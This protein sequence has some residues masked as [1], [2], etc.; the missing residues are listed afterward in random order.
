MFFGVRWPGIA[1]TIQR[2]S[3]TS[4]TFVGRNEQTQTLPELR[5]LCCGYS[6]EHGINGENCVCAV[7][8]RLCDLVPACEKC[9]LVKLATYESCLQ[10]V[11]PLVS[12]FGRHA[13]GT[14]NLR[15]GALSC[16]SRLD[17]YR[18]YSILSNQKIECDRG[19]FGHTRGEVA[20]VASANW[21]VIR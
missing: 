10:P 21:A 15:R 11:A 14:L 6:R 12:L 3:R 2:L 19:S 8:A 1:Q 20:D 13:T 4:H 7:P 5:S 16:S 18:Q 17:T 9:G